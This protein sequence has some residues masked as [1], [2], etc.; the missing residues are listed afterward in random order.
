MEGHLAIEAAHYRLTSKPRAGGRECV[1]SGRHLECR[2]RIDGRWQFVLEIR[3][4]DTV[5]AT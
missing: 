5:P 3:N 2:R 4:S 1:E